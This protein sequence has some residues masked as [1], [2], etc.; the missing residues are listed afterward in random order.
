MA[1]TVL[2]LKEKGLI[3]P[4]KWLPSNVCYEVITGSFAY[5][6]S[7]DNS[8]MDI[9]GF[10]IPKK[11]DI[12]PNLKGLIPGFDKIQN[13]EQYQQHHILDKESR[14]EYDISIY[15]IIKY[16]SLCADNNPNMID[17][18][19]VPQHCVLYSNEIGNLV[20][21]NRDNFLHKGSYHKFLGYAYSQ[22]HKMS[23]NTREGKRKELYE[24]YGFDVKFSYHLVRLSYECEM[25][26]TEGTLDLQRHREHLK[27]IRKGEVSEEDIRKWFSEKEKTL[28]KL[29]RESKL[30]HTPDRNYLRKLLIDCL[31]IMYQK[32]D[33]VIVPQSNSDIILQK[34]KELVS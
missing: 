34:I 21:D 9:Y 29:Y 13:F 33:S 3:S 2:K 31:E 24:K 23:S 19:Y 30:R 7:S 16:F 27:A 10:C 8:D 4:P 26:L 11:E 14:K 15:N 22:L 20:R 6:V 32:L 5:G 1:S 28:E 25:I 18:L 17:T 12:F